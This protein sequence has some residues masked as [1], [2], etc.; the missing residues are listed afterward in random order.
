MTFE[1]TPVDKYFYRL[2]SVIFLS[3]QFV[4]R[5]QGVRLLMLNNLESAYRLS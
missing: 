2:N 1:T 3:P 5:L 4:Q